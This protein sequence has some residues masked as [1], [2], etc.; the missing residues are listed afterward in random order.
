[1]RA[2]TDELEFGCSLT[3]PYL[4]ISTRTP[5]DRAEDWLV[6]AGMSARLSWTSRWADGC[7]HS[8]RPLGASRA[9]KGNNVNT[10]VSWGWSWLLSQDVFFLSFSHITTGCL[11]LSKW[12][13]ES[14]IIYS[15]FKSRDSR[16][17]CV[18][19]KYF[20]GETRN[21]YLKGKSKLFLTS[22]NWWLGFPFKYS[23]KEKKTVTKKKKKTSRWRPNDWQSASKP[24]R[25]P[26]EWRRKYDPGN[27]WI[28]GMFIYNQTSEYHWRKS[29]AITQ[30]ETHESPYL[31]GDNVP[32]DRRTFN[33]KQDITNTYL[34]PGTTFPTLSLTTA[35]SSKCTSW[36][37]WKTDQE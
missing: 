33:T 28:K 23:D 35:C 26:I 4:F 9:L 2:E 24:A 15:I 17:S 22:S 8:T 18:K 34:T 30:R 25:T 20:G 31:L 14:N 13:V 6:T 7:S 37:Q 32:S 5:D 10:F 16:W 12:E 19:M 3:W 29:T 11:L 21:I 27:G 1:M 36:R